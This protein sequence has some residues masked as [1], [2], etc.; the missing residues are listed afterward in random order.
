MPQTEVQM[1]VGQAREQLLVHSEN[2]L[3]HYIQVEEAEVHIGEMVG[4]AEL[5]VAE[6]EPEAGMVWTLLV[7]PLIQEVVEEEV[8]GTVLDRVEVLVLS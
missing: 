3:E 7:E 5:E 6:Q 2:H 1:A 4:V 8:I